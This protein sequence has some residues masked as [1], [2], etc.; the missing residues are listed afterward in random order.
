M[1]LL[2]FLILLL[3]VVAPGVFFWPIYAVLT[4]AI[5][6]VRATD[7]LVQGVGRL[8]RRSER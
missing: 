1:Y 6:A 2:A 4:A 7:A 5:H 8:L 3:L